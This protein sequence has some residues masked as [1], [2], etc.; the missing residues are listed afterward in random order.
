MV[1][2]PHVCRQA[3]HVLCLVGLDLTIAQEGKSVSVPPSDIVVFESGILDRLEEVDGL[4]LP[5]GSVSEK[6]K[7]NLDG[8]RGRNQSY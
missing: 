6:L 1:A 3:E 4:L 7:R 5:K 2:V 8:K